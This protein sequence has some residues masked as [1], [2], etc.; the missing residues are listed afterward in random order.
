MYR[1]DLSAM[2]PF[3]FVGYLSCEH[4]FPRGEVP[5]IVF[6]R[7]AELALDPVLSYCGYH[8]CDLGFCEWNLRVRAKHYW[9]GMLVPNRCDSDILVPEGKLLYQAPALILHYIRAHRYLPPAN[10]MDAV[11]SCPNV[12]SEEY[13]YAIA[14]FL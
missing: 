8:F 13:E 5:D 9:R 3:R 2:G 4:R 10:F 1:P 7:L 14:P 12:K 6:D 11:V